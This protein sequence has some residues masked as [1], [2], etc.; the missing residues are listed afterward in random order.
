MKKK[1]FLFISAA[2]VFFCLLV[3]YPETCLD[4]ALR[5]LKSWLNIVIPSMLPFFI[6]SNILTETG[7]VKLISSVFEPVTTKL[8]GLSGYFIYAFLAA[9][10]SG[11][12][13]GAKVAS[14]LCEK[15]YIDELEAAS[16]IKCTS[17]SGPVFIVGAVSVGMLGFKNLALYLLIPHYV[18]A[19][20]LAMFFSLK[21]KKQRFQKKIIK[22]S[23]Y[24][25]LYNNPLYKKDIGTILSA[26]ISSSIHSILN[27][28][29]F[30][31]LFSVILG[32]LNEAGILSWLQNL[33][34]GS[35]IF[36][37]IAAGLFEMTTGCLSAAETNISLMAK[38]PLISGIISFAGLS[39]H[40]QTYSIAS[41]ANININGFISTKLAQAVI[42]YC[43][44]L[45]MLAVLKPS[46]SV[47]STDHAA[48]ILNLYP[49]VGI[50]ALILAV[51]IAICVKCLCAPSSRR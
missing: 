51:F 43:I 5:A 38:V 29:G 46:I 27:I 12:P 35:P 21:K 34:G 13:M 14:D 1:Y 50:I 8:F 17:V 16:I 48:Q 11:Y 42:S 19:L 37:P 28:G 10:V 39:V 20:L 36:T 18:S 41:E 22:T 25:F 23:I 30:I 26:S 4:S 40:A 47:F 7:I 9:A 44:T 15:K 24:D 45:G 32:I 31:I 49:F 6:A 3:A 33:F 2:F